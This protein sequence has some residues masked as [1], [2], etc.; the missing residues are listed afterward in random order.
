[1]PASHAGADG[2]VGRLDRHA[3]PRPGGGGRPGTTRSGGRTGCARRRGRGRGRA[4]PATRRPAR[5]PGPAGRRH[6]LVPGGGR[7]RRGGR[8]RR[9]AHAVGRHLDQA[10]GRVEAGDRTQCEVD[11]VDDHGHGPSAP[12]AAT[13]TADSLRA[14]P[15]VPSPRT[16]RPSPTTSP[17]GSL[18]PRAGSTTAA[19]TEGSRPRAPSITWS[20]AD[21][22]AQARP[23]CSNSSDTAACRSTPRASRQPSSSS[24]ASSASPDPRGRPWR[25]PGPA[26]TARGPRRPSSVG[27]Q[28]EQAAGD[29]VALD[30][31]A[32][33][34]DRRRPGVEVLG[35][36]ALAGVVVV[37]ISTSSPSPSRARS[38]TACSVVASRTLSIDVSGPRR[39]PAAIRYWVA[40]DRARKA[41]SC[42]VTSPTAAGAS[43]PGGAASS[44]CCSRRWRNA[45]RC[46]SDVLRSKGSRSIATAQPWPTSPSIRSRGTATSSK[47][48]SQNSSRPCIVSMGRTVMPGVSMS[49]NRAVI[50]RWADSGVPVR[51]SSTQRWANWARLVHT[52]WPVTRQPSPSAVARQARAPRLLPVPG[53]EKPWHHVSSPRSSRGTISAASSGRA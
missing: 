1:M 32:A 12:P 19:A 31:G 52:F 9:G 25:A 28:V 40:R 53:S 14:R 18:R 27:P 50:P 22:A 33:A 5:G 8:P 23:W 21:V 44:S 42:S 16:T 43:A 6:G 51:V 46:H 24:A 47:K 38:N 4:S 49:T 15:P 11:G 20:R 45:P 30:L 17:G 37:A 29:D 13:T 35:A 2:G 41:Y 48:T 39:S 3:G 26:R 36:P 7:R 10:E 34:V